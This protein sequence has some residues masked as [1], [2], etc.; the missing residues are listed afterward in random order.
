MEIFRVFLSKV[1]V[2]F[3]KRYLR[4]MHSADPS[5]ELFLN[6]LDEALVTVCTK[7]LWLTFEDLPK[8]ATHTGNRGYQGKKPAVEKVVPVQG[9]FWPNN[10]GYGFGNGFKGVNLVV[11]LKTPKKDGWMKWQMYRKLVM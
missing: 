8:K 5:L 1:P 11:P 2:V 3:S 10:Q 7:G 6:Y 4:R 9:N